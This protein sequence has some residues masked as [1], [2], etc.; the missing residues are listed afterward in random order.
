MQPRT[1]DTAKAI[2]SSK[3][4]SLDWPDREAVRQAKFRTQFWP[5]DMMQFIDAG[6]A[7]DHAGIKL[8]IGGVLHPLWAGD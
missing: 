5:D 4:I 7:S 3:V 8:P 6:A 2:I 1:S